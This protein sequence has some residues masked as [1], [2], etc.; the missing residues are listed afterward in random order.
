MKT[1]LTKIVKPFVSFT[2]KPALFVRDFFRKRPLPY[3]FSR[4]L[5]NFV[6]DYSKETALVM[7]FGD[8]VSIL[9]SHNAQ[10]KS[11]EKSDR[12]NK[13]LLI[14]QE[15]I[16]RSLDLVLSIVPPLFLTRKIKKC[17][18]SGH[19]TTRKF[20]SLLREVIPPSQGIDTK[21]LNRIEHIRPIKETTIVTAEKALRALSEFKAISPTKEYDSLSKLQKLQF[22][23]QKT[24]KKGSDFLKAKVSYLD[25]MLIPKSLRELCIAVDNQSGEVSDS[26]RAKLKNGSA[27]DEFQGMVNGFCIAGVIGYS[28]LSSNVIMPIV[29]NKLSTKFRTEQLALNGLTRSDIKRRKRFAYT[30]SQLPETGGEIFSTFDT[31][32]LLRERSSINTEKEK[33]PIKTNTFSSFETFNKIASQSNGLRI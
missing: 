4:V 1:P 14:S 22:N 33:I 6:F 11:L 16:E 26:V 21:N 2:I 27:F 31:P 30:N 18:E 8:A 9:S 25:A 15:K 13:D 29:R 5:S 3:K 28:I 19:I 10:I 17:V 20:Q 32:Y 12:E 23:T 24:L 7:L